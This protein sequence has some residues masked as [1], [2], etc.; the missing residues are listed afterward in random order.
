MAR[1]G[2]ANERGYRMM[3]HVTRRVVLLALGIALVVGAPAAASRAGGAGTLT[4]AS[5]LLNGRAA[6]ALVGCPPG[7]PTNSNCWSINSAGKVRGLGDVTES[8]VL[9]VRDPHTICEKWLATPVLSVAGKGTIQLSL[10]VPTC[11]SDPNGS[12]VSGA[13]LTLTVTGGTGP[14]AGSSGG[15]TDVTNDASGIGR[16]GSDTLTATVTAPN[17]TF[18]LT[19]PEISA[20]AKKTVQAPKGEKRI[21]VH[22]AASAH[23]LV[24]GPVPVTC[25]PKSGTFFNVGR[26]TG[27][28]CTATDSSANTAT[29]KFTVTVKHRR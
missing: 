13:S 2:N 1:R 7:E 20:P 6:N 23:D 28:T 21:R 12:G 22:Y 4:L 27:V 18:D 16:K 24:D 9:I 26:R 19:P 11:I 14:Y 5:V 17:A 3:I 8:G 10:Q 25:K 29:K 15:G